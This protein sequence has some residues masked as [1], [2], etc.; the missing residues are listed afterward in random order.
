MTTQQG[1]RIILFPMQIMQFTIISPQ[2]HYRIEMDAEDLQQQQLNQ[3]ETDENS[4]FQHPLMA[5]MMDEILLSMIM[6]E[7]LQQVKTK[8]PVASESAVANLKLIVEPSNDPCPICIESLASNIK[9]EQSNAT[10][11]L[12]LPCGHQFHDSCVLTWLH[13]SNQCPMC[14]YEL[15]TDDASYND[16]LAQIRNQQR[17]QQPDTKTDA[18]TT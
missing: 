11:V 15:D 1:D 16:Q 9:A 8:R 12:E 14:R 10:R 2:P 5:M 6:N 18:T 4:G 7:S 13:E 3:S 17:K